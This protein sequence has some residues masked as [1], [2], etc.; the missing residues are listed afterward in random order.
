MV[1]HFSSRLIGG[2]SVKMCALAEARRCGMASL[3]SRNVP[4]ALMSCIRS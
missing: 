2:D 4:R 1:N 3:D